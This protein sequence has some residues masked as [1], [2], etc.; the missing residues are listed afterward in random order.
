MNSPVLSLE[1]VWKSF[2]SQHV[3]Q[4]LSLNILPGET[5]VIL[6]PSG[7][8][9]SVTLKILMGLIE[10]DAGIVTIRGESLSRESSKKKA[11]LMKGF[12]MLFQSAALF[13]SLSVYENVAFGLRQKPELKEEEIHELVMQNLALVGLEH[14]A[15]KGT[16]ELSGGM[17]KR[18]GLARALVLKPGVLLHDE[19]TTGLDP[20]LT[21][22]IDFL[23]QKV[24]KELGTTSLV[25]THDLK[26]AFRIADRVGLHWQGRMVETGA[27]DEFLKSEHPAVRQFLEGSL[28]GPIAP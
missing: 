11:E 12:G 28:N 6:G 3:L 27:P 13:D 26:S 19:P 2:G 4:G 1:N 9:K 22:G 23:I 8:G 17:R 7:C 25:V 21:A 15:H 14:A 24:Q 18:V 16:S 10:P 5:F 20:I